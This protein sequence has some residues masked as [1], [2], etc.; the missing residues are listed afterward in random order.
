MQLKQ[1]EDAMNSHPWQRAAI[2]LACAAPA[3]IGFG[4]ATAQTGGGPGVVSPE[5]TN[6]RLELSAAQRLAIYDAVRKDK[7]KVAPSK[8]P[9]AVGA[10]VP[11]MIEL[12]MLPDNILAENPTTKFYKYTVVQ[13]EVVLVDPTKMRIVAVIGPKPKQ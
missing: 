10:E 3:L 2:A 6:Q 9:A 4:I 5:G 1:R 13:D 12:Y 7:S 8:F 11:P